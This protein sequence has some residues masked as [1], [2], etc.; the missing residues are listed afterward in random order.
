M[1][2][3]YTNLGKYKIYK[4]TQSLLTIVP[5]PVKRTFELHDGDEVEIFIKE[6]S[7]EIIPI[8]KIPS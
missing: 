4:G 2:E 6:N 3:R 5:A 7:W 1:T 8:K